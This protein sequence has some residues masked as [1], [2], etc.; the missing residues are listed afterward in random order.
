MKRK[1][2]CAYKEG[3]EKGREGGVKVGREE[4]SRDTRKELE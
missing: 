2:S 1:L 4:K 3:R